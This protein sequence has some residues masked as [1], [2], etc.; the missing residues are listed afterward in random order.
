[1]LG[2]LKIQFMKKILVFVVILL[3]SGNIF[4]QNIYLSENFDGSTIPTGWTQEKISGTTMVQWKTNSG[5]AWDPISEPNSGNPAYPKQGVRNALF[6]YSSLDNE[7][8]K[9]ITPVINLSFAI[10]PEI[11]FWHAQAEKWYFGAQRHDELKVYFKPSLGAA[12]QL[13]EYYETTVANWTYRQIQIPSNQLTSTC[14]LAFE[15][16][17]GGGYGVCIDELVVVE[18]GIIPKYLESLNF[19]Q[20]STDQVATE[21]NT[22]P[23]LRLDFAVRGNDGTIKLDSLVVSSLNTDDNDINTNGVKLYGSQDTLFSNSSQIATGKNFSGGKVSFSNINHELRT[24]LSSVWI[25]YDIKKDIDHSMQGHILDARILS[26]NIKINSVYYPS[27]IKSPVGSR[28]IIEAIFYDDFETNKEWVLSGEFQRAIPLGLGGSIGGSDPTKAYSGQYVLGTDLT[29]LGATPG[30]Y[31]NNLT[32]REYQAISTN[33]NCKYYKDISVAF[34]RWLNVDAFDEAY[35]DISNDN[36]SSW[37]NVW[38]NSNL[39]KDNSWLKTSYS[40]SSQANDKSNVNIRFSI[41]ITDGFGTFSGWNID[42]IYLTGDFLTVDAG[43]I[44]IL[45][46]N[47]GCGHSSAN[48]IQVIIKNYAGKPTS[49]KI[50]VYFSTNGGITKYYDTLSVTIPIDGIDTLSLN[51]TINL[52]SPGAYNLIVSTALPGDEVSSNNA[53]TKSFYVVPTY[54]L[55]YS[56]SFETSN[57]HWRSL[58]KGSWEYEK[59]T[60]GAINNA[61]SGQYAWVTKNNSYYP[62]NDSSILESP[63]FD[64]TGINYPIFEFKIRSY[65]IEDDGMALYY[66]TDNGTTWSLIPETPDYYWKWYNKSLVSSLGT[67]GWDSL[68]LSWYTVRKILPSAL[69]NEPNVKFRFLFKSNNDELYEAGMGVDD[70]K[71][72]DAPYDVGITKLKYPYSK[73]ELSDTTNFKVYIENYVL[74][75]IKKLLTRYL[76]GIII[77]VIGVITL[78]SLGLIIIGIDFQSALVIGL[79]AGVFNVIPYVGPLIGSTI[80]VLIGFATH[81]NLDF[82]SELVPLLVYMAIVFSIVQIIDNV[83]FQP[84][85]YSSSVNAHPLEIFIVIMMAASL[86]GIIGMILAVPSYTILRVFA[87]EFFNNFKLVKKLTEKI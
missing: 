74:N 19:I 85:I 2:F 11:R 82:Y 35:I 44:N 84:F 6:Q 18:T 27:V 20:A 41:G 59:P 83:I 8:T 32:D 28:S 66:S 67:A 73:C 64:F 70:I 42:N 56:Q 33:I 60:T 13:L 55:P 54:N 15:G 47:T 34:R 5:G 1:M 40:I 37:T 22:N 12:W 36:K 86:A 43:I 72:Y 39:V 17:T 75:S 3:I 30:D 71:L 4:C 61:A 51:K 80:G 78:V 45:T 57:G 9:L 31:E 58:G 25:T 16:K 7:K 79:V 24:G 21:S 52:T 29:G 65:T 26:N 46:P 23:I 53:F 77:E 49:N 69:S 50:P 48:A 14:Y 81:L 63:C 87:K 62:D 68:S 76:I 10:K 38:N